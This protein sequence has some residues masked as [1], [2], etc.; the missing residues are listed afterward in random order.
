VLQNP[1]VTAIKNYTEEVKQLGAEYS[2]LSELKSQLETL[3][4]T[5]A[6]T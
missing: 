2:K 4:N 5:D 1:K 6:L 3:E